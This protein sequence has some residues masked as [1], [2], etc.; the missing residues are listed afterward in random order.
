[1]KRPSHG[2]SP[3]QF[4]YPVGSTAASKENV[5][6]AAPLYELSKDATLVFPGPLSG[7]NG[8]DYFVTAPSGSTI[9]PNNSLSTCARPA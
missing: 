9:F 5:G 6:N 8:R 3:S 4:R 2:I 1:M 7:H